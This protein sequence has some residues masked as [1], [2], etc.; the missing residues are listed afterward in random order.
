MSAK[1]QCVHRS[2]T[3]TIS[4]IL[5]RFATGG[6]NKMASNY[7]VHSPLCTLVSSTNKTDRHNITEIFLK[8]AITP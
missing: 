5:E 8:V 7:Y 4:N 3:V 2:K 6:N 1:Q